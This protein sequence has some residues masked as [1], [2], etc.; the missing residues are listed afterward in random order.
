MAKKVKQTVGSG[1]AKKLVPIS[2]PKTDNGKNDNQLRWDKKSKGIVLLGKITKVKKV[3]SKFGGSPMIFTDFK[4]EK[5]SKYSKG[6]TITFLQT[7]ALRH[8]LGACDLEEPVQIK[9]L[10]KDPD[11][12]TH[13]YEVLGVPLETVEE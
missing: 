3:P 13:E 9:Y 1:F 12:N 10:G 11:T 8:L 5:S 4:V 7:A 6:V 2:G